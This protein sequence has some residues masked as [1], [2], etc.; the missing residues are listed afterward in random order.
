MKIVVVTDWFA[1]KMGYAENFLPKALASLGVEVHVITSNVQPYFSDPFYKEVYEPYIGPGI[2]ECG[3]RQLDGYTLHRLP[4]GR[5]RGRLR[6]SGLLECIRQ[7]KP[8][9]VQTFDTHCLST[10]EL[11]LAKPWLGYKL[12]HESHLH[13]SVFAPMTQGMDIQQRFKWMVYATTLGRIVS[14]MA[15]KCYPVSIDAADIIVQFFG[16]Q[17]SKISICSLGVDTDLFKIACDT[18]L[19]NARQELRKQLGFTPDEIVCIYTGRLT[20]DKGPLVLAEAISTLVSQGLPF[21][22]LFVGS[23]QKPEQEAI[24]ACPGC[25]THPFVPVQELAR[26]YQAVDI[27]VWPKQEST[28]QLDAAACGLPIIV[29]DKVSVHERVDGN[30]LH[31]EEGNSDHLAQQIRKLSDAAIRARMGEIGAENMRI[32]FSWQRIAKERLQDY[33]LARKSRMHA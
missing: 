12:F 28:S 24:E 13:A 21:R 3:V 33:E 22:G 15:E 11:T 19:Q 4:H 29:S 6:I 8:E 9:I 31:Y 7:I 16:F 5:W 25:V 14:L 17:P 32:N 1:E 2:V 20:N 10:Y 30:G 18:P 23:G 26:F 27:G